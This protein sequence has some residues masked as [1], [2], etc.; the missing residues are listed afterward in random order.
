MPVS[1]ED[2]VRQAPAFV[3]IRPGGCTG[4]SRRMQRIILAES[5][6]SDQRGNRNQEWSIFVNAR[7]PP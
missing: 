2:K 4:K 6:M 7:A 1:P 5:Q 3:P